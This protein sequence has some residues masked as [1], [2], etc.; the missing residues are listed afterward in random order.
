MT[1]GF[2]LGL[3]LSA[4]PI[5]LDEVR[6]QSRDNLQA[7]RSELEAQ[8][9]AINTRAQWGGLAPQVR[10]SATAGSQYIGPRTEYNTVPDPNSPGGFIRTPTTT[11]AVTFG[12]FGLTAQVSQLLVDT[13]RWAQ[14]AEAGSTADAARGEALE[15][16]ATSELEGVRRFY[17]LFRAQR[18]LAVLQDQVKRSEDQVA[19]ARALFQAGRT[20]QSDVLNAERNLGTDR[21]NVLNQSSQLANA[22]ADL[23]AWLARSGLEDLE[24]VDPQ[25]PPEPAP[26]PALL[27]AVEVA[28]RD[29]PL[30]DALGA[31]VEVANAQRRGTFS[32]FLPRVSAIGQYARGAP[33]PQLAFLTPESQNVLYGALQLQ[34]DV[35]NGLSDLSRHAA[36]GTLQESARATLLLAER[37][38]EAEVKKAHRA[39]ELQTQATRLARENRETAARA[40]DLIRQRF[41][42]GVATTLEVRDA[43]FNLTQAELALVQSRIDV[44]LARATLER[45]VGAMGTGGMGGTGGTGGS[46]TAGGTAGGGTAGREN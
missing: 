27:E 35:F 20:P 16:R 32:S 10:L 4:T 13:G 26:A 7:L 33:D 15:Q 2:I 1:T 37:E 14:I 45:A 41:E 3:V 42:S 9:A 23:A 6:A 5:T 39:V 17:A 11:Q 43:Q 44:E 38:M 46:G 24:A 21:I 8:R 34:W 25:L 31:R 22:Q 19:R 18:S 40:V 12:D 28:R 29:R 36:A 30:L